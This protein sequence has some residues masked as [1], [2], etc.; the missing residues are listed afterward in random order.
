MY[1][2][3]RCTFFIPY[4]VTIIVN[5]YVVAGL[6]VNHVYVRIVNMLFLYVCMYVQSA[7]IRFDILFI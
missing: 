4:I 7:L 1:V 5:M 3:V 2:Y 6:V